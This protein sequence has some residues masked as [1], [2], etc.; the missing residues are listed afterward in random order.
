MKKHKLLVMFLSFISII[1]FFT[2]WMLI[3]PNMLKVKSIDFKDSDILGNFDDFKIVFIS[4]IHHNRFS[5]VKKLKSVVDTVN[6]QKPDIV[7]I[8]GDY[9]DSQEEYTE[10]VFDVF[11]GLKASA[12]VYTVTGNHDHIS[13]DYKTQSTN[14]KTAQEAKDA[15]MI[16]ID[17]KSEWI[18]VGDQKIKIGGVGDIWFDDQDISAT[19]D[20]VK[21][22]DFVILVSHSPDFA[23]ELQTDKIDLMLSGHT[24]AGQVTFFG[25][26]APYVPSA[27]GNKYRY[28][29][30]ETENTDLYVTSGTGT[31]VVPVR[32]FAQPEVVV[33]SLKSSD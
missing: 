6:R 13:Y 26:W 20:D 25:L 10:E 33:F 5:S 4:D 9:T 17:N 28:G 21:R 1:V 23:E 27:Y 15:G 24:H 16:V 19:I 3:E 18:E 11:A 32:F 7:I 31:N 22:E 30:Y 14:W 2:S 29:M 12:G 8:G